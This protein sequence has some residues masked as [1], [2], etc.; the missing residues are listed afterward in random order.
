MFLIFD[1]ETTGFPSKYGAPYT[2]VEA[3]ASARLVQLA[4]Q[5]HDE[6][7][8]L[9]E[10]KNFIVKP[11]GFTIP[12]NSEKIH[13]ISTDRAI[14]EGVDLKF[15]LEEF[16]KS[17][18][19]AK[20]AIGHNVDFDL[21]VMGAEYVR[22]DMI[23]PMHDLARVDTKEAGT[24][25]CKL[26]GGRG[27]KYK[28]PK[29]IELYVKLFGEEFE[30][31]HNA[32]ADVEATTRAFLEMVRLGVIRALDLGL[33]AEF[34]EE[35]KKNNPDTIQLI[36]LNIEAYKPMDSGV[37]TSLDNPSDTTS[38]DK[39]TDGVVSGSND[40]APLSGSVGDDIPFVHL[41]CHTQFSVLQSTMQIDTLMKKALEYKMPA[42]AITD[43][44]NMYG[45]FKFVAAARKNDLLPIVGC[46]IN[47]CD[48]HLDRSR[49]NNGYQVVFLAKNENGYRNLAKLSSI[50]NTAGFYYVPR[51]DKELVLQ[52]KEDLM[53][54]SGGIFG[55]I[56]SLF[57][58]KGERAA[59]ESLV[60][61]K[62][63][64]GDDFYL[65]INR[66]GI[67]EEEV[68][69]RKLIEWSKKHD[70][71][72]IA[73]NNNFYPEK[74]G[75][76]AHDILLCVK[77]GQLQSVPKRFIGKKGR[78]FRFGLPNEEYYYKSQDEMQK[79]F[80]DLPEAIRNIKGLIDKVEGFD[81]YKDVLLP[82]FDIPEEFQVKE[83]DAD[84]SD[85][86][87]NIQGENRY[88]RHITYEGAKERYDDITD[89]IK[90][91]LDFELATIKNTGYPGY[92]LIVADL[93]ENAR[94]M[95]VSVGPGRGSAAGSAVAYCTKITNI[96]PIGYDL[97][98]ERFLNPER[99]SLPD[100]DIDFDDRGREKVMEWVKNK[101]GANQVTQ[102][103]TYGSM[104]AKSAIRDA[105][106][107]LDLPLSEADGLA[108]QVPPISLKKLFSMPFPD[109][110][111]KLGNGDHVQ[112]AQALLNI[113]EEKT[114]RGEVLRQAI[115]LEGSMRNTGVHAC[116][117]IITPTDITNI[118]PVSR[119]KDS[120]LNVTQ[121]DNSV[122][123]DAGLLKMDFLG[124]KTLTLIKDAV[125]FVKERHD[126][127]LDI[128]AISLEDEKTYEL[129]KKGDTVG[130]FQYESAGMRK[131]LKELK[132][133]NFEDLIAMNALYRPGPIQY[134]PN[135][136]KR[137]HGLEEI[138]YDL[139][140]MESYLKTTYGITV[141]Q[142]QV[143]LLSQKLANFTKGEADSL[144]KAMGKKKKEVIDKMWPKFLE[145]CQKNNHD[146]EKVKKIWTDWEAFASYAFNR[147]HSTCYAYIAFQTAY[148]KANYPA[149]Y[150]AS[151]LSNNMNDLKT[152]TI[153]MEEC[154]KMGIAVLG[155]DV[156][157][158]NYRFR[159]NEKGEIRFGLG[160]IKGV[161]EGAVEDIVQEREKGLYKDIHD[162]VQRVNLRTVNKRCFEN[163]ILGGG[164][165]EFGLSRSAYLMEVDEHVFI[166]DL[167]KFGNAFQAKKDA[168]PDLFGG[169]GEEVAL[170]KPQAPDVEPWNRLERLAREKEVVGMY[171]SAH[172]LDECAFEMKHFTRGHLGYLNDLEKVKNR[173]L[174]LGGICSAAS[175]RTTKTGKPMG[176][177]TIED[178]HDSK[179]FFLFGEDYQKFKHYLTVGNLLFVKGRV[180]E[181]R[182]WGKPDPNAPVVYE[183]KIETM[184][185]LYGIREARAKS[186]SLK[187]NLKQLDDNFRKELTKLIKDNAGNCRLR[188]EVIDHESRSKVILP[189]N[190]MKV[191]LNDEFIKKLEVDMGLEYSVN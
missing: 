79:L 156:N 86:P 107:V 180:K 39:L 141:Y 60:W 130:I 132:P 104:A 67:E 16:N 131:Y 145:G 172:P 98:F 14:K 71:K 8:A 167:L 178:Y 33:P 36:G 112:M 21:G 133:D 106:R 144:R 37:S 72:L 26:P 18:A 121:F 46:E 128:E 45:V 105:A 30:E 76:N 116:G 17:M 175:H 87:L 51:I 66:H 171:I 109:V 6:K 9:I 59:E 160:A 147:S 146:E 22:N 56:P 93:I 174:E 25:Y 23:T 73:A 173:T 108:K 129:F 185:L 184:E 163:L 182:S 12:Y 181:R 88:L 95:G 110:K 103:I 123:E 113:S 168:P 126:I 170:S 140:D 94:K 90:E 11:E 77:D 83:E 74:S 164:L 138:E 176:V 187:L 2:D 114:P 47:V 82:K 68:V 40:T 122:V 155:P 124:L 135:F 136:I 115:I 84:G 58:N 15:V 157:E 64:F 63:N 24:D 49:Q 70:V 137:K 50:A 125:R 186:I 78:D 143:M 190:T 5:I 62:E 159:V 65:E 80:A 162:L 48:D 191:Q 85:T 34:D 57:L 91:R 53:V 120:E 177:F 41:H 55:E 7:G 188:L 20:Y 43:N 92:F 111:K 32:S 117:V 149:E 52:Y 4:W 29:L 154:R 13:G 97:L 38:L 139:P 61:W 42:V 28:W 142:E 3:W 101:Y 179:E 150:M 10:V 54:L 148:L 44:N 89:E 161:G 183:Y 166:E 75:A 151:I 96:D 169:T 119:S 69:N 81:L 27:G 99:V 153:F 1:T 152:V 19:L 102:I 189:S 165:D 158:S 127:D 118:I 134:I 31:A 100:I 35:F